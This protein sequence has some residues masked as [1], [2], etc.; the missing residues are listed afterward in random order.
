MDIPLT[1]AFQ[2]PHFHPEWEI[3]LL[4]ALGLG[5]DDAAETGE[6]SRPILYTGRPF[7]H[8]ACR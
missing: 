7:P 4:K 2:A 6:P 3:Q 8:L 1:L 5:D